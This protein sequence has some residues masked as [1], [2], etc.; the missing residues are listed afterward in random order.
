M[1]KAKK[2]AALNDAMRAML[3]IP[4]GGKVLL[5]R[6]IADLPFKTQADI[7][8]KVRAFNKFNKRGD[9]PYGEHDFGAFDHDGQKIFWKIDY[10]ANDMNYGSPDPSD[11]AV[12][13]R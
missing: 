2:I 1:S 3:P 6:S 8:M 4:V 13:Q 7:V 5:T 12:T 10:Y 11:P 9:D